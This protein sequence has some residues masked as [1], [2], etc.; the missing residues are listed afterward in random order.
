M[1]SPPQQPITP[2]NEMSLATILQEFRTEHIDGRTLIVVARRTRVLQSAIVALH[3]DYFDWHKCPQVEFVGEMAED[4]GGPTREFMRLLMKEVQ[5]ME[6]FE[7][8][9]HNLLFAYNQAAFDQKRF[10]TAGKL[11]AWSIVH[12][13]PGLRCLDP[14]L[15]TLMCGQVPDFRAFDYAALHESDVQQNIQRI[16]QCDSDSSWNKLKEELGDWIASCGVPQIYSIPVADRLQVVDHILRHYIFL[17]PKCMI[18][19]FIDG[20]NSCGVLWETVKTSWKTFQKLFTKGDEPLTRA[21]FKALYDVNWSDKGSNRRDAEEETMFSFESILNTI[22]EGRA[23]I[24]FE[25]ILVF[26]TGAD[27]VPPLGFPGP[28]QVDFLNQECVD[29]PYPYA[30]T[31]SLTLSLPRGVRDEEVLMTL[32]TEAIRGSVEF[33]NV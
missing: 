28:L 16:H 19:Q 25:D 11:A 31:C 30:S 17:R 7:G 29:R 23:P 14:I 13:G 5:G 20:F 27:K 8:P 32:L 1:L 33:G 12:G 6:V 26:W 18:E 9:Q 15:Y 21:E 24:S 3:K 10:Y 2:E 22:E 4:F